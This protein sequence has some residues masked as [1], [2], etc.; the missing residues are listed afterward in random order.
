MTT[1]W[2]VPRSVDEHRAAVAD[3]LAPA[4]T[5]QVA[6]ADAAGRVLAADLTSAVALPP[7]DN[8]AMDGFAVRA[9]ELSF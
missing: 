3:L 5:E 9:A 4:G 6:L 2:D 7:F 8:S 1:S